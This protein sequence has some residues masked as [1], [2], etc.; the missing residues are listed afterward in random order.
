LTKPRIII[1]GGV[2]DETAHSYQKEL[3]A[4]EE[5]CSFVYSL[6]TDGSPAYLAASIAVEE[7][8]RSGLFLAGRGSHPNNHGEYEL[9]ASIMDG[10]TKRTGSVIGIKNVISPISIARQL[11]EKNDHNAFAGNGSLQFLNNSPSNE[12]LVPNSYYEPVGIHSSPRAKF[13]FGTVGAVVQDKLGRFGAATSTGGVLNKAA[14]RVGDTPIIG[15]GTWADDK[16][17]VS[18]SGQGEYILRVSA[19]RTIAARIEFG[20][21]KL[22]DAAVQTLED[23]THLGGLGGFITLDKEHTVSL[24]NTWGMKRAWIDERGIVH[25]ALT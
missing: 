11:L 16:T 22:L 12:S 25:S 3:D 20:R 2:I 10:E 23:L 5:I 6:L 19:A 13:G 7:M 24:F 17:G 15:A 4:L 8:E 21:Q 1:H 18:C 14:G 9:D